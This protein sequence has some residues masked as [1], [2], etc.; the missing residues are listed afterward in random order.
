MKALYSLSIGL[1]HRGMEDAP[2]RLIV[3]M[4]ISVFL[5]CEDKKIP[6]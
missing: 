3:Y 5:F 4:A 2:Q 6:G 1:A